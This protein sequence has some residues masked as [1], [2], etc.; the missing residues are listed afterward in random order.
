MGRET[1]VAMSEVDELEFLKFLREVKG[2]QLRNTIL[3]LRT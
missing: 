1:Q 2:S 3:N